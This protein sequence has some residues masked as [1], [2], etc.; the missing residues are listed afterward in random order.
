MR[1]NITSFKPGRI[2]T[3]MFAL[4]NGK[5]I[6]CNF[7]DF[8]TTPHEFRVMAPHLL[9]TD[10]SGCLV[11]LG[12]FVPYTEFLKVLRANPRINTEIRYMYPVTITLPHKYNE[13]NGKPVFSIITKG[14]YEFIAIY[15]TVVGYVEPEQAP[16]GFR[17]PSLAEAAAQVKKLK[18]IPEI[19][20][21][22]LR[23]EVM[24]KKIADLMDPPK[25]SN[26]KP[27]ELLE[28]EAKLNILTSDDDLPADTVAL[29]DTKDDSQKDAKEFVQEKVTEIVKDNKHDYKKNKKSK[30]HVPTDINIDDMME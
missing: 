14:S 9:I 22:A 13:K 26:A 24:L 27:T 16:E 17:P 30:I 3:T 1:V 18:P 29:D 20:E 6:L 7:R 19:S 23:D 8:Y 12:A 25:K 10:T 5:P 21:Q 2:N 4:F 15:G 28:E 11:H